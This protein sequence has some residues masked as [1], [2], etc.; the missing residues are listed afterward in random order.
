M[1]GYALSGT[2]VRRGGPFCTLSCKLC[3]LLCRDAVRTDCCG[4]LL[5]KSCALDKARLRGGT[6]VVCRCLDETR[7]VPILKRA[8]RRR[9]TLDNCIADIPTRCFVLLA[10]VVCRNDVAGCPWQGTVAQLDAHVRYGCKYTAASSTRG[11]PFVSLHC[12]GGGGGG[13]GGSGGDFGVGCDGSLGSGHDGSLSAPEG[14]AA[15][16]TVVTTP[17]KR[18][19]QQLAGATRKRQRCSIAASARGR[20]NRD[21]VTTCKTT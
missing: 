2:D 4:L 7:R 15:E 16:V 10:K 17:T 20:K 9:L 6:F 1:P 12:G 19:Y 3:N 14:V 21:I 13:G 18:R 5:C 8:V 11:A